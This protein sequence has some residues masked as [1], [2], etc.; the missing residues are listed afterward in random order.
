VYGF[1]MPKGQYP[2]PRLSSGRGD[3]N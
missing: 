2:H 3:R 1:M